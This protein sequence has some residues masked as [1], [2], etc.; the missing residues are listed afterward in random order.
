M[1]RYRIMRTSLSGDWGELVADQFQIFVVG[2]ANTDYLIRGPRLPRPGETVQGEEFVEAAGGKGVNQAVAAARLGASV[3]LVARVGSDARGDGIVAALWAEGVDARFVVRDPEAIT[4]VALIQV[5]E[6]GQKAIL[7]AAGANRRLSH[8]DVQAAAP[9]LAAARILL[10]QLEV[11]IEITMAAVSLT[12]K[13]GGQVILDAG[14]AVPLP[15]AFLR[16]INIVR[17]NASEAEV[18]SGLPV[19]DR[20]SARAAAV[21]LLRRGVQAAALQA[22]EE[23]NLLVW[24]DGEAWLPKIPVESIDATGAGDTFAAALATYLVGGHS[25]EEVGRFA[26][27]AA[28]LATTVLGAQAGLPR[29]A[30][31]E[32]LLARVTSP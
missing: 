11:P 29:R 4:G 26:N 17:A 30:A 20:A 7:T 23:G 5:G 3:G 10:V 8:S 6:Q 31:V 27:A 1:G 28:A 2:A 9:A 18:I 22:G 25:L 15:D 32:E 24:R 13:A 14:P 12:R 21:E 19:R 16:E